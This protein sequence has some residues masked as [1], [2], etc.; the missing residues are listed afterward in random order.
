[1]N[2]YFKKEN[3]YL[4]LLSVMAFFPILPMGIISTS[5]LV[6]TIV[7][8]IFFIKHKPQARNIKWLFIITGF[9][10]WMIIA[11]LY[12]QDIGYGLKKLQSSISLL[13][14]PLSIFL[15]IDKISSKTINTI[16]K[17]FVLANIFL[18]LFI[19]YYLFTKGVYNEFKSATFWDSPVR[20]ALSEN[21][22]K[23]LHPTYISLWLLYCVLY[24]LDLVIKR[25]EEIKITFIFLIVFIQITFLATT[26]LLSARISMIAFTIA[27]ITYIFFSIKNKTF[28]YGSITVIII[29]IIISISNISYLKS[30]LIDEFK[31]TEFSPPIGDTHNS[32]NIRVG[33]YLCS[34][35]VLKSNW[36]F[37]VG[38]GNVQS[39][40]NKCYA[41]F[42][43]DI[44]K[45]TTYNTHNQYL[46][47]FISSGIIG[48]I[49]FLFL[50][51]EQ[52]KLAFYHHDFLFLA[53]II[54]LFV[55]FLSEN[56]LIRIHGV[57]FY[58][59]FS[60][61]YIKKWTQIQKN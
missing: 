2:R 19:H 51:F 18:V 30:R 46:H 57:L 10:L 43:T 6:F 23:D 48:I 8:L 3:L 60:T 55:S 50:L 38:H 58:V 1:M 53:F 59:L 21:Y 39:K 36:L 52:L 40:L 14:I 41:Q 54:L 4:I 12:S 9:Y 15:F 7:C 26:I 61:L 13:I 20:N 42:N 24:L 47:I 44:Y 35:E 45:T 34:I 31:A 27:L 11:I 32:V 17:C 16:H 22:F 33:V 56:I 25:Y 37:G 49:L 29:M 28:K 5:I